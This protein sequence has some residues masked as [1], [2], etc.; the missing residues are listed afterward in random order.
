MVRFKANRA[1]GDSSTWVR[2]STYVLQ[3]HT[4]ILTHWLQHGWLTRENKEALQ[5]LLCWSTREEV[6]YFLSKGSVQIL[7]LFPSVVSSHW[8]L[9]Q[10]VVPIQMVHREMYGL[11][12]VAETLFLERDATA[13]FLKCSEHHLD[14]G[15]ILN[16]RYLK[17]SADTTKMEKYY[18][19]FCNF[20]NLAL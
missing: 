6:E 11:S 12:S 10:K 1:Q 7:S 17:T 9:W 15:D 14:G 3:T 2:R 20:S 18:T 19:S 5:W 16:D 13:E 8:F 4:N